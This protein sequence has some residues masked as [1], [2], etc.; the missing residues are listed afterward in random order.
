VCALCGALGEG[1]WAEASGRDA[2]AA[3][4]ALLARVLEPFGIELENWGGVVYPI[5]GPEGTLAVAENVGVLWAEAERLAS[6]PLDPLD[7]QLLVALE[8]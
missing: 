1:H 7:E 6:R 4:N 8:R 5:R 3:R 2:R